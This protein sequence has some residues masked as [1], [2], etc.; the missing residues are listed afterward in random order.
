MPCL[1]LLL[2]QQHGLYASDFCPIKDLNIGDV[3]TPVN[4]K[5]GVET[6]PMEELK[7]LYMVVVGYTWFWAVQ[8]GGEYDWSIGR[9]S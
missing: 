5:D 2:L 4:V 3:L 9:W 6:A 7:E 8:Q 1:S